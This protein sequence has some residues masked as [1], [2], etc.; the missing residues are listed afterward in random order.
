MKIVCDNCGAKYSIAD[1]KVQGKVFKIRCK[2][3]SEVIVVQGTTEPQEESSPAFGSAYGNTGG[4]SEWYVVV[5]GERVGPITPEEVEAYFTAGQVH[6]DTFAWRDG[7]DDWVMLSTL[8]EF[9]HLMQDAA[10]PHEATMIASAHSPQPSDDLDQTAMMSSSELQKGAAFESN[11][12][13]VESGGYD[14]PSLESYSDGGYGSGSYDQGE[15]YD[16]G[17]YDAGGY[18]GGGY[19]DGFGGG[20]G[21]MFAAFDSTPPEDDYNAGYGAE[22]PAQPA[23]ASGGEGMVGARNENSVLFSLS[24]V[25]Q[26]KAVSKPA[27]GAAQ[28]NDKSGLIDIQ[29]LASSH[30]AMKGNS[31]SGEE[32]SPGTMS[33]PALMPMGSH[34]KQNK[35]LLIGVIAG[36]AVLVVALV[37]VVVVLLGDRGN[38][39]PAQ[40]AV[41]QAPAAAPAA[42]AAPTAEEQKEAEEAKAAAAAALAAAEG[43]DSEEAKAEEE[44]E[45]EEAKEEAR[46][47]APKKTSRSTSRTR[48][49]SE[50]TRTASRTETKKSSGSSGSGVDSIIGQ[51][52]RSGSTS[53]SSGGSAPAPASNVPDSLSR[54]QVAGTIRKYNSQIAACSRD[55]N[56]GGLSGT[57]R[58]RFT[59]QPSGSVSGASVQ[60]APMAGTDLGGCIERV[61]NSMRFPESKSELPITYPFVMR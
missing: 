51:L 5:E 13:S 48:E 9:A 55:S 18:E 1:D 24:S 49:R 20:E 37:A 3:C 29:A 59:V 58:V 32:F 60:G 6:P 27:E 46:A 25:D 16:G 47:E 39:Q 4:A 30:S 61:V 7:L 11:Q 42:E 36:A 35:G 19:D 45:K 12:A 56:S 43:G 10:G 28:G 14:Q 17:G 50:S 8:N 57:A 23:A 21:G 40:P 53:G 44:S 2:K 38:E 31:G 52:D 34:R 26:V 15:G 22:E 41:A 33:M 54:S